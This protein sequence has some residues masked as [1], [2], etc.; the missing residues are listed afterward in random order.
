M[1]NIIYDGIRI[2]RKDFLYEKILLMTLCGLGAASANAYTTI[3][4]DTSTIHVTV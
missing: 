2:L 4:L 1:D 3:N